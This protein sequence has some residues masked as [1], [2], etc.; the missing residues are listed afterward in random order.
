V[1]PIRESSRVRRLERALLA[2]EGATY[3]VN[4]LYQPTEEQYKTFVTQVY[5]ISHSALGMC[6]GCGDDS[7]WLEKIEELESVLK[8]MN[9]LDVGKIDAEGK[10]TR[11]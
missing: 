7:R 4:D 3:L 2:L 9:I 6:G 10:L 1:E 8:T 11:P 5:M